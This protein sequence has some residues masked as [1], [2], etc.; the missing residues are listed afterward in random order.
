[1]LLMRPV[2][3]E[4][5]SSAVSSVPPDH[6][7]LHMFYV[8]SCL[9][10]SWLEP[11]LLSTMGT[12]S[13]TIAGVGAWRQ[14]LDATINEARKRKQPICMKHTRTFMITC[15]EVTAD[16]NPHLPGAKNE[17]SGAFRKTKSIINP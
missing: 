16:R 2:V 5:E 12:R 6:R 15:R 17:H 3:A 10:M 7:H 14:C 9:P 4:S 1:M 13:A 11:F 8:I